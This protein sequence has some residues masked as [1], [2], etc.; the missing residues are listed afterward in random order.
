M[1]DLGNQ[2]ETQSNRVSGAFE[3]L[4]GRI[5]GRSN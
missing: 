2:A 5:A 4:K 3:G 1:A